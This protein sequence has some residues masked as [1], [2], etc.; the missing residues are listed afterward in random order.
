MI[1]VSFGDWS[2]NGSTFDVRLVGRLT[3]LCYY[4][5]ASNSPG[6]APPVFSRPTSGY[7]YG[8]MVFQLDSLGREEITPETVLGADPALQQRIL[9]VK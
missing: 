8:T 3:L 5:Q 2:T 9:L 7:P 4:V 1:F 6:C